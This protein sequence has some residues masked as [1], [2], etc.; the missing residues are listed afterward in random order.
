MKRGQVVVFGPHVSLFQ[1]KRARIVSVSRITGGLT[2]ELMD[3]VSE[4][5]CAGRRLN[6][7]PHEVALEGGAK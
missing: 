6:V 7:K 2:V 1:G 5:Y 4:A 3:D